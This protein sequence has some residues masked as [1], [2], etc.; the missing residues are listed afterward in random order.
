MAVAASE[1]WQLSPAA[2]A[3]GMRYVSDQ[4]PRIRQKGYIHPA[5]MA[6]Y[7]SGGLKPIS[8]KDGPDPYKLS[9]EERGLLVLLAKAAWAHVSLPSSWGRAGWGYRALRMR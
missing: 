2:D 9:A 4:S 6:A 1:S 5:V 8:E 3:A 7:L